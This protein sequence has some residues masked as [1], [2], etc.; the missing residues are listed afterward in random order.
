[1]GPVTVRSCCCFGQFIFII[2]HSLNAA[3][4]GRLLGCSCSSLAVGLQCQVEERGLSSARGE[5]ETVGGS[6]RLPAAALRSLQSLTHIIDSLFRMFH[7]WVRE[8]SPGLDL[9]APIQ[10]SWWMLWSVLHWSH[11]VACCL[12]FSS[13]FKFL[14]GS[15]EICPATVALII[16]GTRTFLLFL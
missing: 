2:D 3:T 10:S 11:S 9:L 5:C 14:V 15:C 7:C 1:M 8:S 6:F 4:P 12:E 13:L 16:T